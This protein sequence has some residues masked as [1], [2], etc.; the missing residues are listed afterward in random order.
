[1]ECGEYVILDIPAWVCFM[2]KGST[3]GA[4]LFSAWDFGDGGVEPFHRP[5]AIGF[6]DNP[7]QQ[8]PV[9]LRSGAFAFRAFPSTF[10]GRNWRHHGE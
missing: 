5:Y 10:K 9:I 2:I 1:M 8:D 3:R 6:D 7:R 4:V